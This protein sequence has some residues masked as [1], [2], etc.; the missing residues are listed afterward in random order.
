MDLKNTKLIS[1]QTASLNLESA[2]FALDQHSL[3]SVT[4]LEGVIVYVNDKFCTVSGYTQE[5]LIG[6]KHNLLNSGN[7]PKSYWKRMYDHVLSGLVWQDEVRNRAKDGHFYWVDTTIVPNFDEHN[8][9]IG[10][11]SIRTDISKQK[12]IIKQLALAKQ[13]AESAKFALDQHSLVSVTDL[14]GHITYVNEQ[15]TKVSGYTESELLG[16]KHNILNSGNQPK[17]YWQKMYGTVLSGNVW[18]DEVKN[19]A[20]DGSYYWVDTTIVPNVNSKHEVIGFTSIRTDITH[21]KEHLSQIALAKKQAEAAKFALDQHSLVS[22]ADLDGTITY[23]NALFVKISGY[24]ETE[25]I[26]R[27]HN[28]L[29]SGN[30]P[31]AYWQKMHGTVLS[32]N[33]WHD[34]VRNRAKD[35]SYYWVDTTI[36]P[37]FNT[38]NEVIGFTSIR[39]DITEQKENLAQLAHAKKQA[40]SANLAKQEFLANMSH[41]IRTPMNGVYA[42]LQLLNRTQMTF[43]QKEM[44]N[45]SLFSCECL[46]TIINDILDFSKIE[47]GKLTIEQINFSIRNTLESVI[48]DIMP[49][50]DE[51]KVSFKYEVENDLWDNWIG[52]PIRTKQILLNLVSNAVKFTKQ[53]TISIQFQ[54]LN[55]TGGETGFSFKVKDTGIGMSQAALDN[56]FKRF[57]QADSSTTRH[58]GGTGLGM[59]ITLSLVK[60][61]GGDIVVG[62]IEGEGTEIT[63]HLPLAK[64]E[65]IAQNTKSKKVV[66][67]PNLSGTT[68]LIADDNPINRTIIKQALAPSNA[69]VIE[70]KHGEE[71]LNLSLKHQPNLVLMDIHMPVMD[72]ITAFRLLK[73]KDFSAPVIAFTANV[74]KHDVERY[75]T[76]GFNDYL[77]KPLNINKLYELLMRLKTSHYVYCNEN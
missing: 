21:Q 73:E 43:E 18:H 41:E 37:N 19:R 56:L 9:V 34:E 1:G 39:T 67:C 4:D 25:L 20:K 42:S 66:T 35:G 28:I 36:V 24:S 38:K 55:K 68:I 44:L 69:N 60:M 29:N 6:K 72:G 26:G 62:S 65:E 59:P 71:A 16:K 75:I 12:E 52:D 47:S 49:I 57:S 10:F 31:K 32:G 33:V 70:A 7:Q 51:E 15:F 22:I 5:E 14:A 61:M 30:Q 11:T 17:S 76:E 23:V 3:V 45:Q 50:V 48:S 40:E 77:S 2:R 74:L 27:K 58:F 53:G 8:Q 54:S 13:Q 64:S 63:V 46:L